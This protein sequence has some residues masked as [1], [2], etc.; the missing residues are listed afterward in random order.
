MD[1]FIDF[2]E[3]WLKKAIVVQLL[4]LFAAQFLLE[5]DRFIPYLNKAVA[6]EGVIHFIKPAAKSVFGYFAGS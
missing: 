6:S 2:V 5:F 3:K 1:G 4:F